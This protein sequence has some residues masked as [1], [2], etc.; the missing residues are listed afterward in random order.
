[1][2][3]FVIFEG[4]EEVFPGRSDGILR[5]FTEIPERSL[6]DLLESL[7]DS[8]ESIEVHQN[9]WNSLQDPL[10]KLLFRGKILVCTKFQVAR[11]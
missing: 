9:P 1:L 5:R 3:K 7:K 4:L 6:K 8:Y 2:I 10:E 11:M